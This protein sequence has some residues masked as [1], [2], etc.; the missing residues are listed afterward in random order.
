MAKTIAISGKGGTG[1]TTLAAMIIRSLLGKSPQAI[2]AVDADANACLGMALGI[3]VEGTISNLRDDFLKEK[4]TQSGISKLQ[5]FGVSCEQLLSESKGVDLLT[6]GRPE[7]PGC[8]CAANNVLRGFLSKLSSSYGYVITD[9]EAGME[10]LSRRTTDNLD[11]LIIA[12]EVTQIGIVTAERIIKLVES[13][14]VSIGKIGIIWNK[15][16]EAP[17]VDLKG[18]SILG[19]VPYD[20][21]VYKLASD[22]GT[23]FD[24]NENSPALNAVRE[25]LQEKVAQVN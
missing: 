11:L 25:I 10:H 14:P 7:G 6:M 16:T 22:G 20:E 13:L 4:L 18:V 2:L 12:A 1:K 21:S 17:Q 3:A 9:N 23:I 5:A 19:T 8:Y 24:L 15:T